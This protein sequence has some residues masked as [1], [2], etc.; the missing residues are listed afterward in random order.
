MLLDKKNK[1]GSSKSSWFLKGD[2]TQTLQMTMTPGGSLTKQVREKFK[3]IP[4]PDGGKTLVIENGGK[5]ILAGLTKK[6]PFENNNCK[7][8]E[9]CLVSQEQDCSNSNAVYKISC[10]ECQDPTKQPASQFCQAQPSPQVEIEPGVRN[11][12]IGQTGRTL[13]SRSQEHLRGLK[14]GDI[15]CPLFKHSEEK[16]NGDKNHQRFKMELIKSTRGNLT[17]LLTESENI[18]A[19]KPEILLNS[20]S[21]YGRNKVVRFTP[22]VN[23]A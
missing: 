22:I 12:Y 16:H 7:W 13:H 15:K 10:T 8:N 3:T 23:R 20:K 5:P 6:D 4:G 17:R 1:G 9:P 18:N 11:L 21:E 14:K 2:I 19:H